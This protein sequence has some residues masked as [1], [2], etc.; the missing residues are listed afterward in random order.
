MRFIVV[1]V[2]ALLFYTSCSSTEPIQTEDTSAKT[3]TEE[4]DGAPLWYNEQVSSDS[5][6]VSFSGYAFATSSD[7][8][9]AAELSFK[10]AEKNL[11]FEIDRFAEE[12]R[13]QTA[14]K[15]GGDEL[16]STAFILNLRQTVQRMDVNN[17]ERTSDIFP[18]NSIYR[19]YASLSLPRQDIV[20]RLASEINSTVFT[21]E[22]RLSQ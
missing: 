16:N 14:D 21:E 19:A 2:F 17:A 22:H 1:L 15:P 18:E 12:I 8:T 11:I 10:T 7:S 9:E 20:S 4:D 6:S 5:D 3:V 13:K